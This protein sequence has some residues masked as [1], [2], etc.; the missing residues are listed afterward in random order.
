MQ[1]TLFE[2]TIDKEN[3]SIY[4]DRYIC[5]F[6]ENLQNKDIIDGKTVLEGAGATAH[7]LDNL[8]QELFTTPEFDKWLK[9]DTLDQLHREIISKGMKLCSL[10]FF[11]FCQYILN[12]IKEQY[13]VL[14]KPTIADTLAELNDVKAITF[15]NADGKAIKT[16]NKKLIKLVLDSVKDDGATEYEREKIVRLDEIT[17]KVLIQSSFTYYVALF[18]KEYFKDYPR[19]A[20]CCMVSATEQQLIL[21]MLYFFGLAPAPLTDS[22]FRQLISHYHK[23]RDRVSYS[24]LPEIGIVPMEFIKYKDWKSGNINLDK[25][26]SLKEGDTV[27]F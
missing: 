22:R 6:I 17:D 24:N 14:L 16:S 27:K 12:H 20:N 21:Y 2:D 18:L 9:D 19:R 1:T 5:Y 25:I 4:I 8:T 10:N 23:H 3:N 26:E 13:F 7:F 11:T 15:T